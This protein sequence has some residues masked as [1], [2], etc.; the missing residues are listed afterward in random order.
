MKHFTILKTSTIIFI[1]AVL[2]TATSCNDDDSDQLL[3]KMIMGK[4]KYQSEKCERISLEDP[5]EVV[6]TEE[7]FN[8]LALDVRKFKKN[9]TLLEY[10]N[11]N[12]IDVGDAMMTWDW[13]ISE[14]DL[15]LYLTNGKYTSGGEE[16]DCVESRE[17]EI[18]MLTKDKMITRYTFS[19]ALHTFIYT[20]TY[21]R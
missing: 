3:N 21:V 13:T 4:W 1:L 9:G 7:H 17:E 5:S 16:T 18:L 8:N 2:M 19:D 20:T 10:A 14:R 6:I 11:I 15:T 12:S